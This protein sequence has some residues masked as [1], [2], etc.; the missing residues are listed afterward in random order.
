MEWVA[1]LFSRG[2]SR[3]RDGTQV[4]LHCRRI[5]YQLSHDIASYLKATDASD[6]VHSL[7]REALT[8]HVHSPALGT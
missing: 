6:M 5:L 8:H 4:F 3:S 1:I 7:I 2:S